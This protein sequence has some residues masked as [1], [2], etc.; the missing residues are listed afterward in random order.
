MYQTLIWVTTPG[1]RLEVMSDIQAKNT[2]MF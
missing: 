2:V 1:K